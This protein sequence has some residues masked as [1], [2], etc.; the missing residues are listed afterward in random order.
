MVPGGGARPR[1]RGAPPLGGAPKRV[2]LVHADPRG[3]EPI[4]VVELGDPSQGVGGDRRV[5]RLEP[6]DPRRD[7]LGRTPSQTPPREPVRDPVE[8]PVGAPRAPGRLLPVGLRPP[9]TAPPPPRE[10][11]P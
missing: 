9:P 5:R 2:P 7:G 3:V 11:P 1:R 6:V 4:A 10:A 8:L